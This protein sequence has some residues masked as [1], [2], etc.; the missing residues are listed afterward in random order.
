MGGAQRL[1]P[2]PRLERLATAVLVQRERRGDEVEDVMGLL[3]EHAD[4]RAG[5][6]QERLDLALTMAV[7]CLGENHLWQDLQLASRDELSALIGHWFP[8]LAARNTQAMKWKKFLYKQLCEREQILICKAPS[9]AVC[10]DYGL[11]FEAPATVHA[12]PLPGT[13]APPVAA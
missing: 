5:L 13:A 10:S 8:A 11:C 12:G 7:A 4:E 9:C 6:P 3:L 1:I 2:P